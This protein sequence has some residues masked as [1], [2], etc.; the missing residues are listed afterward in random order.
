VP[1]PPAL[2][3][4]TRSVAE[5]GRDLAQD[6][7]IWGTA[8]LRRTEVSTRGAPTLFAIEHR[9]LRRR[10]DLTLTFKVLRPRSS[11]RNEEDGSIVAFGAA[12]VLGFFVPGPVRCRSIEGT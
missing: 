9:T 5:R 2:A 4:T 6:G 7:A 3:L 1:P 10:R 12:A 8:H 11:L